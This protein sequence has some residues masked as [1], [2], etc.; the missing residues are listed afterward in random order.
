MV[1]TPKMAGDTEWRLSTR[2]MP[3]TSLNSILK[4]KHH[5]VSLKM[6]FCVCSKQN[7]TKQTPTTFPVQVAQIFIFNGTSLS[8]AKLKYPII[9]KIEPLAMGTPSSINQ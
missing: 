4:A 7:Y 9:L 3:V 8:K 5:Q 2:S 1:A 6:S